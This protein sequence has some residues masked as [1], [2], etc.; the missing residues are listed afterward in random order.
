M[1][2]KLL[3]LTTYHPK[4]PN[5]IEILAGLKSLGIDVY[6]LQYWNITSFESDFVRA[7]N[8]FQPH[9]LLTIKGKNISPELVEYAR[10]RGVFTIMWV[11]HPEA[12][13]SAWVL[14][15]AKAHQIF[16][17]TIGGM[18]DIFR[19]Q[20]VE[21]CFHL[22]QGFQ[23]EA[24]FNNSEIPKLRLDGNFIL[25]TGKV[26]G[27]YIKRA[28]M[29]NSIL[30]EGYT[31]KWYGENLPYKSLSWKNLMF[32]LKYGNVLRFYQG[33][34]AYLSDLAKIIINSRF[35]L[36]SQLHPH[37][38]LC[39]SNRIWSAMGCGGFYLGEYV[40]G[41]EEVF[42]TGID[43]ESFN[44]FHEMLDKI[45]FYWNKVD[46]RLKIA[47]S[48]QKKILENHTY[49]HRFKQMIKIIKSNFPNTVSFI[50]NHI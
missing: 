25:F 11:E 31:V 42:K 4:Y 49:H 9:A 20:G 18:V 14:D 16:F 39:F 50:N 32:R 27:I 22:M 29:L 26:H 40:P 35:V 24:Y 33:G 7:I 41:Q 38:K 12:Q 21:K 15:L 10:K 45:K 2:M 28:K 30:K 48:G 6:D 5:R 23:P 34:T 43:L 47:N 44:D 36:S 37:Y 1:Q 8:E 3:L 19:T 17:T 46:L 13:P